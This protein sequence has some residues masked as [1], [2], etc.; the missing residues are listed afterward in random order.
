MTL[1]YGRTRTRDERYFDP[2]YTDQ[3]DGVPSHLNMP[4]GGTWAGTTSTMFDTSSRDFKRRLARGE[5]VMHDVYL[6]RVTME[7]APTACTFG[8]HPASATLYLHGNYGDY[9]Y[10]NAPQPTA[11]LVDQNGMSSVALQKC[12]A[13]MNSS[14]IMGGEIAHDFAKSLSML[15]RPFKS[16]TDL[17]WRMLGHKKARM[18][19]TTMSAMKASASAWLEYRYGWTPVVAD[20]QQ[21]FIEAHGIHERFEKRRLVARSGEE[22]TTKVSRTFT[23]VNAGGILL[24]G[25]TTMEDFYR[26]SAGVI[27][28]VKPVDTLNAVNAILGFRPNDLIALGWEVIPYSFVVDWFIGI[29]TWISAMVPAPGITMLGSWVTG[30]HNTNVDITGTMKYSRPNPTIWYTGPFGKV[31]KKIVHYARDTQPVMTLCPV[32]SSHALSIKRQL[33]ALSLVTGSCMSKLNELQHSAQHVTQ[34][35]GAGSKTRV[36]HGR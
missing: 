22:V 32:L 35:L 15:R 18:K 13:K 28:S 26:V 21:L 5:V 17:I 27:Y 29:G 20:M 7:A 30:V 33:D 2:A 36:I 31:S 11:P 16:A 14:P 23:D 9:V 3:L 19:K 12:F 4:N 24:S 10:S 25:V 34:L 6:D 1:Y 8:P